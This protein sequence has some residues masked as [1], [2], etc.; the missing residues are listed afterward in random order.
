M[1]DDG[2]LIFGVYTGGRVTLQ[3]PASYNDGA[4]HYVV[5]TQGPDGM[6]LY[7]DGELVASNSTSQAASY[8]GYWRVGAD[9]VGAWPNPPTSNYFGGAVS[10]VAFYNTELSAAQVRAHYQASPAG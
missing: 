1:S 7:V 8:V 6:K 3:S 10:D 4:W 2:Q 9:N 5:A